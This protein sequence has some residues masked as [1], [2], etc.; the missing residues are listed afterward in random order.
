MSYITPL[1]NLSIGQNSKIEILNV[2]SDIKPRLLDLGFISGT[3]IRCILKNPSG[4][5]SAYLI[6]QTVIAL[7]KEDSDNIL[8]TV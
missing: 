4:E 8:V 7:R 1:S 3:N 6:R 5:L 2:N